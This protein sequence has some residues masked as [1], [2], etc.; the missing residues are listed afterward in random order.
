MGWYGKHY[1]ISMTAL[2]TVI[3]KEAFVHSDKER[4]TS[5]PGS[6]NNGNWKWY[7]TEYLICHVKL[8]T[9][10]DGHKV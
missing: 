10:L 9:S 2:F 3:R 7:F 1:S 5:D 8:E 4:S 6:A